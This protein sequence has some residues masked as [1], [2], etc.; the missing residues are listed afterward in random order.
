M[1]PRGAGARWRARGGD[2][3]GGA[4]E[5][6]GGI[7]KA[8]PWLGECFW[9][10]SGDIHAPD[11]RFD[12]AAAHRFA[13]GSDD[14]RLWLVPNPDFHPNGDFGLAGDRVRREGE[15]PFTYA[16]YAL[17]RRR[18]VQPIA[19]GQ[20]APLGPLLFEAAARGTLG[21]EVLGH[22]WHNLGTPQQLVALNSR[23]QVT[24]VTPG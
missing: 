10:V 2:H 13:A 18:L 8:L 11:F 19:P 4:L 15:R 3:H 9:V 6:A 14:A 21:G 5:T 20:H 7:A 17:V 24:P 23:A 12:A 22:E 1:A 16:N